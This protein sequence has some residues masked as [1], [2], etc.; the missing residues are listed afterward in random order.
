MKLNIEIEI[1]AGTDVVWNAFTPPA[2]ISR[3]A[4]NF[5]IVDEDHTCWTPWCRFM[6][7][8]FMRL[9]SLFTGGTIRKRTEGEMQRFK[10]MV[11]SDLAGEIA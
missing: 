5:E 2:N 3:W 10:S 8:R 9:M 11:E 7:T 6:F 1:D 4:Q